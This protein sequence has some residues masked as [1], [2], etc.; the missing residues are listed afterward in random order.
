MTFA[1]WK[2]LFRTDRSA[3]TAA[4]EERRSGAD[5]AAWNVAIAAWDPR[6]TGATP[7]A[8]GDVPG[9]QAPPLEGVPFLVKDLFDQ[10]GIVSCA[11]SRVLAEVG[12]PA[13]A[14]AAIVHQLRTAGALSVGRTQMNEFAYGLDGFNAHTGNVTNPLDPSRISGG[15]S[16]GSAWAVGAGV[17]PLALGTDT[18]G[19]VRVPAAFCGIYG[20]RRAVDH[21]AA[22]GVVPLATS[23][24]TAGWF[25]ATA[26]DMVA[27]LDALW[28]DP[29]TAQPLTETPSV[30]WYAPA[31]VS[32]D[33]EAERAFATYRRDWKMVDVSEGARHSLD[34][35]SEQAR[36]AYN[37]IGSSEAF[38]FHRPWLDTHRSLYSATVWDLIDRARHWESGAIRAAQDIRRAVAGILDRELAAFD[39]IAM[40]AVHRTAPTPTE[41]SGDYRTNILQ[42]TCYA[43]LAALPVLTV[44][45]PTG[46]GLSVG[47]Q[48]ISHPGKIGAVARGLL[49]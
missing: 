14:D 4:L 27:S 6:E 10:E 25:T 40:P 5:P 11:S 35:Q 44:P 28:E 2:Q 19:S 22:T 9:P 21:Y 20:F 1:E 29:L 33:T 3:W 32:I 17:V 43:S 15:S 46:D 8:P 37:V 48:I 36:W 7:V 30:G 31:G 42:L 45:V 49:G 47:I 13:A 16:S 18:G 39:A 23:F 38:A 12:A 41:V 26:V 34:R 24:D